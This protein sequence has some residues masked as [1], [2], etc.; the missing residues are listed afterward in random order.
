MAKMTDMEAGKTLSMIVYGP[1]LSG[2]TE[3]V[4]K[5]AEEFELIWFDLENSR[6]TLFKL[7]AEY[8]DNIDLFA[9]PDTQG[10]PIAIE[11][12]RKVIKGAEVWICEEHGKC[13][14]VKCFD[15][16]TKTAKEGKAV[17][18]VCL[19]ELKP[20]QAVVF[21]SL[22]QLTASAVANIGRNKPEGYKFEFDDWALLGSNLHDFLSYVQN[23]PYNVICISHEG[24]VKMVD[25]KEK[26]VPSIGTRNFS[27][28]CAKYFGEVVYCEIS[29]K[30]HVAGSST[31]YKNNVTT[32]GS[33][34]VALEKKET[35]RLL[36]LFK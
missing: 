27:R 16:K 24:S 12:C 9:I 30:K 28:N 18:R 25:G 34:G 6:P 15:L 11:T 2:K 4:G 36:D 29:N 8:K 14:C 13:S 31:S 32:G 5:L 20:N 10:Y 33:S 23:A 17:T 3:L 26:I 22:S 7:P 1:P 35:P 21:D 19:N